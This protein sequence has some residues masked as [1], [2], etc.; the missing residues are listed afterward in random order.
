MDIFTGYLARKVLHSLTE[1]RGHGE[2]QRVQGRPRV[3]F[4]A[5][6]D[7]YGENNGH[8]A[9]RVH[10]YDND[11]THKILFYVNVKYLRLQ[12]WAITYEYG[13]HTICLKHMIFT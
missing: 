9:V 7:G 10:D 4:I 8:L 12:R 3:L 13:P 11:K 2:P 1:Q 6:S 5:E